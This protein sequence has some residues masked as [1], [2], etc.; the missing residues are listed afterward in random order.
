L[1]LS[2]SDFTPLQSTYDH[3][4]PTVARQLHI[5]TVTI[6]TTI[7]VTMTRVRSQAL[8]TLSRMLIVS[9]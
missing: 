2:L 3:L 4:L 5:T 8:Q 6:T 7:I 9:P 1:Q